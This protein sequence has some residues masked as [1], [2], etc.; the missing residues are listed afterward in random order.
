MLNQQAA[1]AVIQN[2]ITISTDISSQIIS[3]HNPYKSDN[4]SKGS[5]S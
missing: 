4:A 5:G 1:S 3:N 2:D